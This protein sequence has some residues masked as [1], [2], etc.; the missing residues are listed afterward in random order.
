MVIGADVT[1]FDNAQ[2]AL[3]ETALEAL[4]GDGDGLIVIAHKQRWAV[5]DRHLEELLA[6]LPVAVGPLCGRRG[7]GG[8]RR[9]PWLCL[10]CLNGWMDVC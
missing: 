1:F 8:D 10:A 6:R 7:C 9:H 2:P 3:F 4:R 5:N